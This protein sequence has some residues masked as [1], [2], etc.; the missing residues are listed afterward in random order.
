MTKP[1]VECVQDFPYDVKLTDVVDANVTYIGE[2]LKPD[3]DIR[4]DEAIFRIKRIKTVGTVTA[5]TFAGIGSED[6]DQIWDDRAE[7]FS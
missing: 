7:L 1:F 2:S 6:H 4:T 5:E 3:A